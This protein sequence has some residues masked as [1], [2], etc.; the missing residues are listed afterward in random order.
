MNSKSRER[1]LSVKQH[2]FMHLV[3][4][5]FGNWQQVAE[6]RQRDVLRAK[7]SC[8]ARPAYFYWHAPGS[9]H[10]ESA[11]ERRM[12]ASFMGFYSGNGR[13]HG[14][15]HLSR[16]LIRFHQHIRD[17][18]LIFVSCRCTVRH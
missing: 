12:V 15:L 5:R 8:A 13:E 4:V 17:L 11:L 1:V 6:G 3:L 2:F 18:S 16:I 7:T 10:P 14:V 9:D